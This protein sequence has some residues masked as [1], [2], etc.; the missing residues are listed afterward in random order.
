M[1]WSLTTSNFTY[2][3]W[4]SAWRGLFSS[5]GL[6][7]FQTFKNDTFLAQRPSPVKRFGCPLP[8]G[9]SLTRGGGCSLSPPSLSTASLASGHRGGSVQRSLSSVRCVSGPSQGPPLGPAFP[10]SL[11][12]WCLPCLFCSEPIHACGLAHLSLV[13]KGSGFIEV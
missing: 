10:A 7:F 4:R 9:A 8:S 5:Q 2:L 3:C 11:C 12:P 1:T 6:C 13:S